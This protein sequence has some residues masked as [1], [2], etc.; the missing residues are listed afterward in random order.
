MNPLVGQLCQLKLETKYL[1]IT[2]WFR[3]PTA[4]F[5]SCIDWFD[6]GGSTIGLFEPHQ[7]VF[8]EPEEL[9]NSGFVLL[10]TAVVKSP[11][12]NMILVIKVLFPKHGL[13]IRCF[14]QD[15]VTIFPYSPTNE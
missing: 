14:R 1:T 5:I 10:E 8:I 11:R 6:D 2:R 13:L 9:E 12:G 4:D 3:I 7:Y 15:H